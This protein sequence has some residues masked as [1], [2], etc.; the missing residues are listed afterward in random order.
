MGPFFQPDLFVIS[1]ERS[2]VRPFS[3]QSRSL[4]L[5]FDAVSHETKRRE[6]ILTFDSGRNLTI[7][8]NKLTCSWQWCSMTFLAQ[9]SYPRTNHWNGRQVNLAFSNLSQ[10]PK[11]GSG[12]HS[13]ICRGYFYHKT[14]QSYEQLAE[15]LFLLNPC[16]IK[17]RKELNYR[18]A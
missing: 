9:A 5:M 3:L 7:M 4:I 12:G 16:Q 10:W 1:Q 13:W 6:K 8:L 15:F 14:V 2:K 17:S 18:K 11:L